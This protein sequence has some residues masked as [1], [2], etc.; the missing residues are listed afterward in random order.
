[1]SKKYCLFALAVAAILMLGLTAGAGATTVLF[2]DNFN[3]ADNGAADYG[4]NS[5]PLGTRH[6]AGGEAYQWAIR[7]T[8]TA[9][10]RAIQAQVNNTAIGGAGM[11]ALQAPVS[12]DNNYPSVIIQHD[13]ATDLAAMTTNYASNP[14]SPYAGF[15][16]RFDI[17]PM[18]LGTISSNHNVGGGCGIGILS[19]SGYV[20]AS[21]R[22]Y[23]YEPSADFISTMSESGVFNAFRNTSPPAPYTNTLLTSPA[24][25]VYDTTPPTGSDHNEWYTC[26]IRV[27]TS[28]FASG[29][30]ATISFWVGAQG[31]ASNSLTQ[32]KIAGDSMP[33]MSDGKSKTIAW[34]ANGT[35]F[36][37]FSS[38][39]YSGSY[40]NQPTAFDNISVIAHGQVPEPGTLILLAGGLVGLLAYAWRKRK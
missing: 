14:I 11:L 4:L 27:A 16:V 21:N 18:C 33:G 12:T 8:T 13:F 24:S 25:P 39:I 30:S 5:D 6:S 23:Y 34:D 38:Q 15:T 26:E 32:V 20:D 19:G 40:V 3:G 7:T 1:M 31:T 2:S 22:G 17:D 9:T 28:S 36:I 35:C 37:D 10:M 29:Q